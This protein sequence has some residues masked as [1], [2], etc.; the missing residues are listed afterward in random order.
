MNRA[1]LTQYGLLEVSGDDARSF[2]HAQLT[3]EIEGLESDR[4]RHAGWCSA[5]GRLL[6][7][8]LVVPHAEGYLLQLAR[9][10]AP[11]VAKRLSMFIL[12]ARVRIADASEGW[13]QFGIWGDGAEAALGE[14]GLAPPAQQLAVA[15][16]ENLLAV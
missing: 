4:A 7:S 8:F 3:N 10:L 2:L 12:R 9:D 1:E 5:K 13:A 14:L 16:H 6:A 15:R 11:A